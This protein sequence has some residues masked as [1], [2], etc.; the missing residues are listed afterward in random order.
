MIAR[1]S[2]READLTRALKAS[3]KA[4]VPVRITEIMIDGSIR[5]THG[6]WE[7]ENPYDNWKG[8]QNARS[9]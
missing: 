6:Q 3:R 1:P 7:P 5:L 8:R 9:A 2:F 4:G